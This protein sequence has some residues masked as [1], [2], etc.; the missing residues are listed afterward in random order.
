MTYLETSYVSSSLVR[1]IAQFGGD[2]SALVP[3]AAEA[4]LRRTYGTAT[5]GGEV[6]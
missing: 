5:P 3:A 1:E 2:V 6:R 4:A